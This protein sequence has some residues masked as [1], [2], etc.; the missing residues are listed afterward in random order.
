[1]S[2]N[3]FQIIIILGLLAQLIIWPLIGYRLHKKEQSDPSY[4]K[5]KDMQTSMT[6]KKTLPKGYYKNDESDTMTKEEEKKF[7]KEWNG[8]T[9]KDV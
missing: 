4:N 9:N 7:W 8:E 5:W 6:R 1:M 2:D 3:T